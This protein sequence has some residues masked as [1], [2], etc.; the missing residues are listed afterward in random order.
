VKLFGAMLAL[1]AAAVATPAFAAQPVHCPTCVTDE[2]FRQRAILEE[3]VT[4]AGGTYWVYNLP[5]GTVQKWYIPPSE[6]EEEAAVR[7]D[8]SGTAR[9]LPQRHEASSSP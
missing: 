5:A 2:D 1:T 6:G 4:K 7:R 3:A 8:P 9:Q